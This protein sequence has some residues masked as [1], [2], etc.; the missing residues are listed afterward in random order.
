MKVTIII[1]E[2]EEGG[3]WAEVPALPGCA[4]QGETREELLANLREAVEG[5]L[6]AVPSGFVPQPGGWQE[7][8]ELLR[9]TE[10]AE[11]AKPS[12]DPFWDRMEEIWADQRARGHVPRTREEIDAEIRAG[13]EED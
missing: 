8:V 5:C 3:Y 9:P 2:T 12:V 11:A 6:L 1:H 7:E 10:P 4:T 13:R